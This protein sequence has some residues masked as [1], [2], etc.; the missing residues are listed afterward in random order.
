[1]GAFG[2]QAAATP[3][4][5]AFSGDGVAL[6]YAELDRRATLLAR[7]LR[8]LGVGPETPVGVHLGRGLDLP[9]ALLGILK[10]GGAYLPLDP[11]NPPDRLHHMIVDAGA[12]VV[13]TR[14][15]LPGRPPP[16]LVLQH[17]DVTDPGPDGPLEPLEPLVDKE[18]VAAV[19]YT[20]GSTGRPKGVALTHRSIMNR[21]GWMWAQ[22]PPVD[23]EVCCLKTPTGFVDSLWELL[24]PL[25][26]GVPSVIP[27]SAPRDADALV[28]ELAEHGVTR[29]LLVPSLLRMLLQTAPDLRE[30]LPRLTL[31]VSSGEPLLAD[32][33]RRFGE[34]MPGCALHNLYGA[35]EVWDALWPA[36][37]GASAVDGRPVP[38]GSPIAGVTAHLLDRH[39]NPVPVGVTGELYVGGACLAR[40]YLHRPDL[41]AD[42]F[43]PHP[44]GARL[45]R[46]GDLGRWR[47]DGQIELLGRADDQVKIRGFRVEPAEVETALESLVQVKQAAVRTWPDP[48]GDTMLAAYLVAEDDVSVPGLR[49]A[50]A[51]L[52]P[53]HLVPTGYVL[54]PDL[55]LTGTG[56]ID[57]RAL[58][59]PTPAERGTST[60][61]TG[62]TGADSADEPCDA[63]ESAVA[64][65]W[66]EVLHRDRVGVHD[67]FFDIGG[68]SLLA[69]VLVARV[70]ELLGRDLPVRTVF[71]HP[72]VRAMA[73]AL[74]PEG[75]TR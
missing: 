32:L 36:D 65:L 55:P 30:R 25:L 10:A 15:R 60:G 63:L 2:E 67:D 22:C 75:S 43:V 47:D 8:H 20:S 38:V 34:L 28:D 41:T 46:T 7:R 57:R 68:H 11:D 54:M 27:S 73:V 31:W 49:A 4:A 56:K 40:G 26:A 61:S 37:G 66:A 59:E 70:G 52:L 69:P 29:L 12:E 74:R 50:L 24:G 58:P 72:T 35:S 5:V 62:G 14:D 6:N 9:V 44:G 16:G 21:I 18:N 19:I 1:M 42:R 33:H 39:L 13:V 17:P 3:D 48:A 23:G 51:E 45:Y 53:A 71:D 64:G